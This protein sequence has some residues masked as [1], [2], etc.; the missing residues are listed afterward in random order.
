MTCTSLFPSKGRTAV[1]DHQ[2]DPLCKGNSCLP[3]KKDTLTISAVAES[4]WSEKLQNKLFA[5]NNTSQR[6]TAD[7]TAVVCAYCWGF[8]HTEEEGPSSSETLLVPLNIIG[9]T[10]RLN[11]ILSLRELIMFQDTS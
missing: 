11:H 8:W 1:V 10:T 6:E 3:H 7:W 9:I 2:F 4:K 5:F